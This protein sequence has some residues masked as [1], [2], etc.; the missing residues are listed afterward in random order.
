MIIKLGL[1]FNIGIC[2]KEDLIN[3]LKKPIIDK[4]NLYGSGKF[5]KN[6]RREGIGLFF[7]VNNKKNPEYTRER[8]ITVILNEDTIFR[9]NFFS[10]FE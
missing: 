9:K 6:K 1:K 7:K 3:E 5:Y 8:N 10:K 4:L 2:F